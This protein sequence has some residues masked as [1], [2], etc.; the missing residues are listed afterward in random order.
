MT[1]P[2]LGDGLLAAIQRLPLRSG[3]VFRHYEMEKRER[4]NLLARVRRAC[5]RRGHLLLVGGISHGRHKGAMSAPVHNLRELREA[6][7]L[8]IKLL[9]MSPLFAT[10]SHPGVSPLGLTRFMQLA[11]LARPAKAI[12]LGGMSRNRARPLDRHVVHGWAGIDAFGS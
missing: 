4:Q 11:R 9:F 7:Q 12:A 5:A 10:R 8:G 2:R 1:D 6:R 3:V